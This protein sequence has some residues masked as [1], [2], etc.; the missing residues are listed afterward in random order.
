[1]TEIR[2]FKKRDKMYATQNYGSECWPSQ[3]GKI[4]EIYTKPL[5][6]ES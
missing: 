5:K 6:E 3:R 2:I 4:K 1:M